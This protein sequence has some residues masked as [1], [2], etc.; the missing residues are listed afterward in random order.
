MKNCNNCKSASITGGMQ[1]YAKTKSI[2]PDWLPYVYCV[3][4]RTHISKNAT[5][6]DFEPKPAEKN[7]RQTENKSESNAED[8]PA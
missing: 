8:K 3:T 2:S 6:I 5:C 1:G 4:I 7:E